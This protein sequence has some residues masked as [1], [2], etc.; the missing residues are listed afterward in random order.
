[1]DKS[2]SKTVSGILNKYAALPLQ[3][4]A[5]FWFLIC[6]FLQK[7]ISSI[8]IPVFTRLMTP[9]EYGQ[10]N[11]FNS[12]FNIVSVFVSLNLASGV[13]MQGL[14]KFSNDRISYISSMQG[15]TFTLTLI[16]SGI[17]LGFYEFWNRIFSLTTIQMLAMLVMIWTSTAF[18]F[19][20]G[21]QRVELRY[22]SLIIVTLLTSFAKPLIGVYFVLHAQDKVTARIL[23][24]VLVEIV[25]YTGLFFI[26]LFRGKQF[27]SKRFWIYALHFNLPLIPHYLSIIILSS[28][29][30]LM[31][32]K[33]I[34][35]AEAGIYSLAYSISQIMTLFNSALNQTLTPWLY[36]KIK[37]KQIGDIA[38]LIFP[39][40]CFIA[41]INLV[42]IVFAPEI[43]MIFTPPEYYAAVN[44]IPPITMSVYFL[45]LYDFLSAFEFYF[46]KTKYIMLATSFG[47]GLNIVLNFIFI[48]IFGYYAAGYTTLFCY[49]IYALCHYK[50][51]RRICK[52]N[53]DNQQPCDPYSLFMITAC[54]LTIGFLIQLTYSFNWLRYVFF[55]GL[56]FILAF[57]YKK[58][59]KLA[60]QLS[61]I[62]SNKQ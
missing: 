40:I 28:S 27:I 15:L 14:V 42:L 31:I 47:A 60:G 58:I 51:M 25:F 2:V 32:D 49:M 56:I 26:Q 59:K 20:A 61:K 13:Y 33:M 5:S 19:W 10:Y 53:L 34:G 9:G 37:D 3:I 36:R 29:D 16:W 17:Y 7:G 35:S 43:I 55:L 4:K 39:I 62:R 11:V 18:Q 46:E 23:S 41:V 12:W 6:A 48:K 38:S 21:E 45:F 54:F 1:M 52:Q 44:I 8:T 50:F 24:L 22:R 57:K 30:R